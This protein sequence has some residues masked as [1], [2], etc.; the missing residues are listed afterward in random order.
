MGDD[1]LKNYSR[2]LFSDEVEYMLGYN[3]ELGFN[4]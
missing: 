2:K 3:P 1:S 4:P